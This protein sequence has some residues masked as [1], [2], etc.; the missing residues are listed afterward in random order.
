MS[1][2]IEKHPSVIYANEFAYICRP[3]KKLNITYFSHVFIDNSG[4]FSG[5]N[6][7]PDFS[8]H[9]LKNNYFNA[10]IHL[11][12]IDTI[13]NYF[14][15]D[16]IDCVGESKKLYQDSCDH[17][18]KHTFTIAEKTNHGKNYYHFATNQS[19]KTINQIYLSNIDLLN[20]FILHFKDKMKQSKQL[21]SAYD[22]KFS[23]DQHAN[24]SVQSEV[25]G[26]SQ[27]GIRQSF[28]EEIKFNQIIETSIGK[29]LSVREVEVLTWLHY[30]K[31]VSDIALILGITEVTVNKHIANIKK[32]TH[33]YTQFQLGEL[34]SK[35]FNTQLSELIKKLVNI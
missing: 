13:K 15:W 14:V 9:Y 16:S 10:D 11:A 18:V 1:K 12:K 23:I 33:C 25:I 28:L 24:Y 22:I 26:F 20:L 32:K 8:E 2:K 6:N 19:D 17:G 34:F 31:T 3:L 27:D 30:G 29:P 21:S 5:V 35:L 7:H 4:H